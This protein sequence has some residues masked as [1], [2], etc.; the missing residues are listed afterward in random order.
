MNI[1]AKNRGTG[2]IWHARRGHFECVNVLVES[3]ADI[4]IGNLNGN[5]ALMCSGC[6]GDFECVNYK[7]LVEPG[8]D[9]IIRNLNGDPA[10]ELNKTGGHSDVSEVALVPESGGTVFLAKVENQINGIIDAVHAEINGN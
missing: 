4:D 5:T 7:Y 3:A 6:K 10:L 8:A 2:L 1:Q 9:M